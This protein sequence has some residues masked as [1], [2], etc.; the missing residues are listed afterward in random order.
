MPETPSR[1]PIPSAEGPL[2]IL[3]MLAVDRVSITGGKLTYRDLS[4]TKP[5][6]YILQDMELLLQNVRLGQTPSLHFRTLVQPFNMPVRL[7]GTVGPLKES[8]KC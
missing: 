1:A 8:E 3:A 7:D 4:A 5:T 2:K 6:E